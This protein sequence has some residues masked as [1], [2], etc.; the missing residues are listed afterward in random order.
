M[1]Q[2]VLPEGLNHGGTP[3][4]S[5]LVVSLNKTFFAIIISAWCLRTSSKLTGKKSEIEL[6]NL[7]IVDS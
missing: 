4:I 7:K 2:V 6:E 1:V 5:V 3:Q